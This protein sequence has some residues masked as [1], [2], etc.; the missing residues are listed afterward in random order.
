MCIVY[1]VLIAVAFQIF[2]ITGYNNV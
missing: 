2:K 1:T